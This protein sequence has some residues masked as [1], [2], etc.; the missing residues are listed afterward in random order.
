MKR[1]QT[2]D[3]IR[4][5]LTF[6]SPAEGEALVAACEREMEERLTACA[7]VISRD[8]VDHGVRVIRLSGPTCAGKT[9]AADKLTD[10]LEAVGRVVYP[11]SIDDFFYGRDI[12]EAK[13]ASRPDKKLDY[14]S[15]ETIDLPTLATCV[16]ELLEQGRSEIPV[17]NFLTGDRD[18]YR[19]LEVPEGVEPVFLFEGI[20]AVYPRVAA[21]F[22]GVPERSL[23]INVMRDTVL[24][25]RDGRERVFTPNRIRLLRRLVRDEA[26]RGS[27]PAFTL[28][29]WHSVRENEDAAIFPYADECDYGLDSN[30][31]YDIHML[32]PHLRRIF[33]EHPCEGE[34]AD[35]AAAGLSSLEGVEGI[36]DACLPPHSLYYEFLPK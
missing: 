34:V 35:E 31:T 10:A 32:A 9:T 30:M 2:H 25:E 15:V 6:S 19:T 13:A 17:F 11:V 14:D 23:F 22:E 5:P 24:L 27:D 36:S 33:A 18:G 12:L 8:C 20:Q 7:A 26:K 29:L 16:R 4:L 28:A 21:L 3:P 1:F